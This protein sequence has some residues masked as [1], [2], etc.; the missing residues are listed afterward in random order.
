MSK[1]NPIVSRCFP[2]TIASTYI[3]GLNFPLY[4]PFN[5]ETWTLAKLVNAE[6]D[7]PGSNWLWTG[8]RYKVGNVPGVDEMLNLGSSSY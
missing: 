1:H 5:V 4:G 7:G 2:V 6:G 3:N 8:T